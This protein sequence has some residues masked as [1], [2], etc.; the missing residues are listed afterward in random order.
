MKK[1][2]HRWVLYERTGV[3]LKG[4]RKASFLVVSVVMIFASEWLGK[5][6]L[7]EPA[8]KW[9]MDAQIRKRDKQQEQVTRI[10]RIDP[11]DHA[12]IFGGRSPLSAVA[13][14]NAACSL[15]TRGASVVVVDLDTSSPLAFPA[16][17][18]LRFKLPRSPVPIIWAADSEWVSNEDGQLEQRGDLVL[19]GLV[20]EPT[21]GVA[22]MPLDFDGLVRR[23]SRFEKVAGQWRPTLVWAAVRAACRSAPR[24]GCPDEETLQ[25]EPSADM[26]SEKSPPP[27][28][29]VDYDFL[30]IRL[31]DF[32]GQTAPAEFPRICEAA[33]VDPRLAGRIV[34]LGGFY[35]RE[36]RHDTPWGTR[37]SARLVA[38][39]IEEAF[40][41][42][43]MHKLA[44]PVKWML[45][46]LLALLIACIHHWVRPVAATAL[47]IGG[48]LPAA[49]L[50]S[51]ELAF[52]FG[53]DVGVVVFGLGIL[54][55]QLLA[56]AER[57]NEL[58]REL[59]KRS[60]R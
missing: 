23:W 22:R 16:D 15:A 2:L 50:V 6:V 40:H 32:M 43:P 35:S 39:A 18:R 47:T 4:W 12:T 3:F 42:G 34:V 33:A 5:S 27:A 7:V 28:M 36:D 48:L 14:V 59:E 37:E 57:A 17:A 56:G 29:T 52:R 8:A 44:D 13:L 45:K 38:M 24:D 10:V 19:G 58:A 49:V 11:E 54:I 1:W 21:Y 25:T 26:S 20:N 30:P 60:R 9:H 46:L 31:S 51:G 53:Y 41:G 55:E